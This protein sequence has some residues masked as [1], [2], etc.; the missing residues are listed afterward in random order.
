MGTN[1]NGMT[2]VLSVVA[3]A[4]LF[5]VLIFI[6]AATR[7]S[8]ARREQR[9]AAMRLVGATPRQ[10]AT[11]ATVESSVATMAG[12]VVGFGLFYALRPAIATIPFTGER[13]FTSDLS[14][15]PA[16]V[17]LVA[18][19]VPAA[20]ALAARIALRR[21]NISPLGVTRRVT[22]RPPRAWRLIPL[23]AGIAWL[24]YLAYFSDIADSRNSTNQAYAYLLGV[25]LI[26]IGLIVAGPWLTMVGSRLTARHAGR[27]AGL[28][29]ARRL[30][31]NPH[32]AFRAISGLVLAVF[33][34]SCAIGIITTIVAY[35]GGAAG[36]TANSTATLIHQVSH[37][38]PPAAPIPPI[39]ET[40]M[41][42]LTS[43]PGVEGVTAIHVDSTPDSASAP[44]FNP[45]DV[46]PERLPQ[47]DGPSSSR[48]PRSPT[49]RRS[50]T[51]QTA[52]TP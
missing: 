35:N 16:N 18:L 47:P 30:G 17:L 36:D 39:S 52:P 8:A 15:S 7:L 12:T 9:F 11:I 10:I 20:A 43:I 4:L 27:P 24:G 42:E 29:A 49:P 33:V 34:A 2:L 45:S 50:A 28:I 23:L 13:F 32:A 14:L 5:P 22:P 31:D 40:A 6:G 38:P 48:A 37:G 1:A 25:F 21:V 26:M 44:A 46:Q 19:G 41:N 3:A 51:A